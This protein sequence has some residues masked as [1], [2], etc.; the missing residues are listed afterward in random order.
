MPSIEKRIIDLFEE[1]EVPHPGKL[2]LEMIADA[3]SQ[4]Q[5]LYLHTALYE[6]SEEDLSLVFMEFVLR[7]GRHQPAMTPAP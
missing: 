1:Y 2:Q 7:C 5:Y 3:T 6:P 4:V